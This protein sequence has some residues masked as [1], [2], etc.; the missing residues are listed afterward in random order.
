MKLKQIL[1]TLALILTT[2]VAFAFQCPA[3]MRQI[4]AALAQNPQLSSEQLAE[5]KKLR[6]EGEALHNAGRHQESVDTL[7]KAKEMLG[8]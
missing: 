4:D 3:D 7:A 5:V 2:S 1:V 8:L 6:E